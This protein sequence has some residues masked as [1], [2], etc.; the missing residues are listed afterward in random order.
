MS[1]PT[2]AEIVARNLAMLRDA[3][4]FKS[5]RSLAKAAGISDRYIGMMMKAQTEPSTDILDKL[6]AVFHIHPWELLLP[7]LTPD[8]ARS[9]RIGRLHR[10]YL[11]SSEDGQSF[12][13]SVA[14]REASY[15]T[16]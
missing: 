10:N 4:G 1:K 8:L 2:S 7:E 11:S 3:F 6:A 15:R 12:I 14:E 5:N 16:R 9:G 13:N